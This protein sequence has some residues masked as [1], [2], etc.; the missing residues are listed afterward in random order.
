MVVDQRALRRRRLENEYNELMSISGSI[1]YIE[2]L[3]NAPY[4]KYR[5]TFNLRTIISPGP[6][7][8]EKTICLLTIPSGYPE[9]APKIAVEESSM[10]QPWHPNWY[11]GGTWCFGY[12]T[13]EESLVNYIYRCAKTIQ[14]SA[15]F[16]DAKIDAA[17]NKEAVAFWNANK[18]K[19]DVIPSDT[20]KL[21]TIDMQKPTISILNCSIPKISIFNDNKRRR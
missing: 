8:R 16:T 14:F 11:R 1:I 20:K 15:E 5:I 12:W 17:A 18:N 10:P 21:P 6:I 7:Y 13:K 4:E 3:G 9:I 2:P 19:Y